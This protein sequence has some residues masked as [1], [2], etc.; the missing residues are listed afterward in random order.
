MFHVQRRPRSIPTLYQFLE[1]VPNEDAAIAFV[2]ANHLVPELQDKD[3]PVILRKRDGRGK[4][5]PCPGSLKP[6]DPGPFSYRCNSNECGRTRYSALEGTFFEHTQL[7]FLA[8]LMIVFFFL[9]GARASFI[10]AVTGH[11]KQT[12]CDWMRFCRQVIA[13][14]ATTDDEG[15]MIGGV[16]VD[17]D[18]IEW[19][20]IVEVDESKFGKVK[21]GHGHRVEGVWVVGGVARTPG[22]EV[23][24]VS[25]TDR[26]ADTLK[27]VLQMYI[28]PG[29]HIM[30]DLWKGY[31][32]EDLK[33][34]GFTHSTVNHSKQ[35][36]NP[37]DGTHTNTVEGTWNGIKQQ[38]PIRNRTS[39][40]V[41]DHLLYFIW[42][43]R[44]KGTL[45][46]RMLFALKNMEYLE[47]IDLNEDEVAEE[48]AAGPA[49]I[50]EDMNSNNDSDSSSSV[51]TNTSSND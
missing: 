25:V 14:D 39:T 12:V 19:P 36:M 46:D 38:I 18:G 16:W 23:F 27:A 13:F 34:L 33:Y 7:T 9:H 44:Y 6:S 15:Q 1:L 10:V 40:F 37:V 3:C 47:P 20:I 21:Y 8:L 43:R 29:T 5:K 41:D 4:P 32:D 11:A 17:S 24:A 50:E 42:R 28:R 26:S 30:T 49:V 35:Y 31:R 2:K 45:W 48:E 22:R 51:S